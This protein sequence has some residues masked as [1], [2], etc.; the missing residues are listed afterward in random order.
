M[1]EHVGQHKKSTTASFSI[2]TLKQPTRGF[3]L[4][5]SGASSQATTDVQLKKP[6]GHDI[7]RMSLRPQTKLTVNQP[8]DVYEQEADKVAQQVMQRMSEPAGN[9]QSIQ[10]QELPE[11]EEE[12]QMK[13]LAGSNISLQ[14]QELPEEEEE[15]QMKSLAGSNISLQREELPEEEEEE[16][17]MKSLAGSSISLQ[18]EEL[19]EEEEEL[20][21]KS[22]AG[23]SISLQRE[24]LPEEEEEL[25]MKSLAGSNIS[26]QREELPEEEEELQMKSLA[27]SNISLQREELPEEEEELQMKSL[28]ASPQA[29]SGVQPSNKPL[30]HDIS[31]MSL[32]LQTRLTVNQP[33]DVYEQEAD[34]VAGQVMQRMSQP[35]TRQSIQ[36]EAL[37]EEE[38]QLQMKSLADSITPVVQ[39]KGGGGI[40]ATSEL[41][42]SIQQARGGGQPLSNDIRQPMEQAFGTDF[43]SVKIH[44]DSRSDQLNQSVQARAFTTG[45]DIFFRQ[46]EYSPGSHGGKE[47]LAHELTHVVQQNGGAVQTKADQAIRRKPDSLNTEGVRVSE[48]SHQDIDIQRLCSECEQEQQVLQAKELPSRTI[49]LA[50]HLQAVNTQSAQTIEQDAADEY[51]DKDVRQRL[52]NNFS[53]KGNAGVKFPL[54]SGTTEPPPDYNPQEQDQSTTKAQEAKKALTSGEAGNENLV[55]IAA[56]QDES[57]AVVET[58][59]A[60]KT[61]GGANVR[62]EAVEAAKAE[63]KKTK[64]EESVNKN[65]DVKGEELEKLPQ[66]KAVVTD[67]T[68]E[69]APKPNPKGVTKALNPETKADQGKQLKGEESVQKAGAV[70]DEGLEKPL[71]SKAAA[72][73]VTGEKATKLNPEGIAKAVNPKTV[74][75]KEQATNAV[76]EAKAKQNAVNT[77]TSQLAATGINFAP[78]QQEEAPEQGEENAIF[79]EQQK[80][81]AISITNSFL[82]DAALRVQT[83]TELGQGIGARIQNSTENAKASVMGSVQQH[84]ATV[85]AQIAQQ[86]DQAQSEAQATIAQIQAQY[87]AAAATTSQTTATSRQKVGTEYTTSLQKV[88]ASEN[89]Q[90]ARIEEFYTQAREKYRA[91]GVKVGDEAIAFGEQKA[92]QW[93]SQITGKDDSFLDGPLTDNRLKARAK[94][95][96]EVAKQYKDGLIEEGNKQ[97]DG[98][99]QGKPKDIEAIHDVA[100]KSREQLQTLQQQ[101]LDNLNAVE[102]Q[103]LSQLAEA[104]NQLTQTANQTLQGTLQSLNQQEVAQLQLLEGYGQRQVSAIERD[105]EKAIASIQDGINQ[106]A[107]NLQNAIQ[108]TQA[109]LEGM[110]APNP[111]ELGVT[112]AEI[113]AQFD[114]SVAKVQ[115]QTQQG[116]TA[117]EQGIVQGGQQVVGGISKIAQSGLEESAAVTQEAKSTL[118]NLNQGATDTFNQI[119]QAVTK[120]VTNTTETAVTGFG[121]TSQ[122]VQTAFDQVNQNLDSNF[123][124]S[125]NDLEEG[126]RGAI[127]GS[128][129][130][131]LDSD[132]QKYADEAADKEQPRWKTV[133][134]V[135]LVIA[136]IVVA[137]IV[138]PALIGA[139][140]A[141]AGALGAGAAAG[142]IGTVVGGAIV[143]A[144]A[145]AVIQMGNNAIDGKNLLDGV[146]KAALV[147]AIGGALGGAGGLLGNALGQAGRLGAGLTQSVLKFGIDVAFDIAGAIAGD[148]AVG[149][150]ITVEGILIGAGIGAA[151]QISTANLGKLGKFGRGIEGMQTR[152][153]Q[154]GERFGTS[155][156]DGIKTGFGGKVDAPT[157]ARPDVDVPGVQRPATEIPRGD[158]PVADTPSS[159]RSDVDMPGVKQPGVE[160]LETNVPGGRTTH[161]DKPEIEPGVVAKEATVDGHEIKVLQDGRI[162]RCSTCGEIRQQHQELLDSRPKLKEE[163]D[164]IEAIRNPDEKAARAREFEQKL[165]EVGGK[166]K[167][168]PDA[169]EAEPSKRSRNGK[170]EAESRG[171]P[172][173][174]EGYVWVLD[175]NNQLRYDR[176]SVTTSDGKPR[177]PRAYDKETDQFVN[178]DTDVIPARLNPDGSDTMKIPQEQKAEYD[179]LLNVREDARSR[180]DEILNGEKDIR[181]WR[182]R[183]EP[184]RAELENLKQEH[185]DQ[186]T[187]DKQAELDK[188]NQ[189]DAELSKTLSEINEQSRKLG[190]KAGE[191]Y[192]TSKYPDAELLYGGPTAS[193]KSGDFDQVWRV[194]KAGQ[195]GKDLWIVVEAKGGSSTLGT[196]QVEGGTAQQGSKAYFDEI[197]RIMSGN[198]GSKTVGRELGGAARDSIGN[199]KYLEVRAPITSN[200]PAQLQD[201]KIREFDISSSN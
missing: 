196:R 86:R 19:P 110:P 161:T 92:N 170:E 47:L 82:A 55:E 148:L 188:I 106:A 139:V 132:I 117:S 50:P 162:I 8:G 71:Q 74:A 61:E 168:E 46:G 116:I 11:E 3:G 48:L 93:E 36:R 90:L 98:V 193:S 54:A 12:L 112:L 137:I 190:E 173:A 150:P 125:V 121:Q 108:D 42:T 58:G 114:S 68:E 179:Q 175:A 24:E 152:T 163:L 16:L 191:D 185:P 100:K 167:R 105:A 60:A 31:R 25:Q 38:D 101:S 199:V 157:V 14:R 45:Q 88:D 94:A 133:L 130:P 138:A 37:P 84:K 75:E 18:R 7:S 120:T 10:R 73:D 118:T 40:A 184:R 29:V 63:S 21:M 189:Q 17:Q 134:K 159:T 113:L 154:A 143:G 56:P 145:G 127:Q 164:N 53:A 65:G 158:R 81:A 69:K 172:P 57:S 177:P 165:Q 72:T 41:E 30:T 136:V 140:G 187:A 169:T 107:A 126:L 122:G 6:L 197:V 194:P 20:Q 129:Q 198:K 111:D 78:P 52:D 156:G 1:G 171:Y 182:D 83:I 144:V 124:K 183:I 76:L 27:D 59:S 22:L 5:S 67:V 146:G 103:T 4:E 186:F 153:F 96:R 142:A 97:G 43:S 178:K 104:Q 99:A 147:G 109:Q 176:T 32:R 151:V 95:A 9:Q 28:T 131:N 200:T 34:R 39:R 160:P 64:S 89:K 26:L 192:V 2:P 51:V 181:S 102:Q 195:D 23:S 155:L 174:E 87:Q 91:A 15:L 77:K 123:Q 49:Q 149:N 115:E 33:G 66:S 128:K 80:A 85:T 62:A 35:G 141:V 166:R 44:T 119:Q 13:S 180:R 79:Q 135:L 201:I 70:K